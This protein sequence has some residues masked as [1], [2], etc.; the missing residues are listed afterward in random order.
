M[1]DR[2]SDKVSHALQTLDR[3]FTYFDHFYAK[4]AD[5]NEN[6]VMAELGCC[7]RIM[8]NLSVVNQ[9]TELQTAAQRELELYAGMHHL[10][11]KQIKKQA[12]EKEK[13]MKEEMS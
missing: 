7:D 11:A 1:Q 5:L 9:M 4:Q 2:K 12:E 3:R 8:R 13:R 10:S 6:E